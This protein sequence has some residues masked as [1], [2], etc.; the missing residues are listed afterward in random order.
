[1][2]RIQA[3][4]ETLRET[5]RAEWTDYNGHMN[6]AYFI[7]IF[8]LAT[9][10]F[11]AAFGLG[12]DYCRRTNHSTFAVENH[13][14]YL[15]EVHENAAVRCTTQLL[16]FDEKRLHYFHRMYREADGALAA[17]TELMA[18][19]VDL[20][21]RKVR[22][23]PGPVQDRLGEIFVAHAGLERPP[24]AGRVMRLGGPHRR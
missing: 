10:R 7:L 23:M 16:G 11:Y 12:E 19:H 14:T 22:P 4:M 24:E 2:A 13:T 9:D 17:T 21:V 8:D 3:P 15:A 1:M 6:L 5:V 18:V 20:G